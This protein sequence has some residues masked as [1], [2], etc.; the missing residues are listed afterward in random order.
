MCE[1]YVGLP[2]Q[3]GPTTG[4]WICDEDARRYKVHETSHVGVGAIM[5]RQL[6]LLDFVTEA[7]C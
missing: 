6:V 4:S 2:D 5:V 1:K 3:G 7:H